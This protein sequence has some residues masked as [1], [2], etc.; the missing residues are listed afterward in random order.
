MDKEEVKR[1]F[2]EIC[3]KHK[4][5]KVWVSFNNP[6]DEPHNTYT[7]DLLYYIPATEE[8]YKADKKNPYPIF[9]EMSLLFTRVRDLGDSN[10]TVLSVDEDDSESPLTLSSMPKMKSLYYFL[11][12]EEEGVLNG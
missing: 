10:M 9:E 4:I 2:V 8:S 1:K 5:A 3:K 7:D 6:F 11:Y 12:T